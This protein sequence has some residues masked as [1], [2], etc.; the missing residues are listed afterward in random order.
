LSKHNTFIGID[1][2]DRHH[3][4]CI[5]DTSGEEVGSGR[6]A[7][8]RAGL[9]KTFGDVSSALI[10]IEAG[11]HSAWTQR[12]LEAMGHTVLVGNPRK[13]RMIYQDDRKS[14]RRDAAMLARIAR[15]DPSLLHPVHHRGARAQADLAILRARDTAVRMRAQLIHTVR[16]LVKNTGCRLPASSTAYF[17][18]KVKHD[19]P[20]ELRPAITPLLET[21]EKLTKAVK[22]YDKKI[23]TRCAK[24]YPETELLKSVP[25]VGPV[26]ALAY[27]LTLE[28]PARFAKSRDAGAYLGLV[29][30]RDQSGC[31]DKQLPISKAGDRYLRRL[32]V[33][34]AQYLLGPFGPDCKLRRHGLTLAQRGGGSGKKRAVVALARKLAVLL[35]RLWADGALFDPEYD[36]KAATA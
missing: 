10:A 12:E 9:R 28:D 11:T 21:I 13:L 5:L 7:S 26:T 23:A 30:R 15:M 35:H 19:I 25:G 6:C 22:D 1:M 18:T 33:G 20:R 27:A 3:H 8:T 34:S 14:D 4:F 16:G 17:H 2:G 29:P 32:L 36:P 24:R 31:C